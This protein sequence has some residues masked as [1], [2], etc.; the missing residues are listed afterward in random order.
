MPAMQLRYPTA[1]GLPPSEIAGYDYDAAPWTSETGGELEDRGVSIDRRVFRRLRRP[2]SAGPTKKA[3]QREAHPVHEAAFTFGPAPRKAAG[4]WVSDED[5]YTTTYGEETDDA[6]AFPGGQMRLA[7]NGLEEMLDYDSFD[8]DE[9]YEGE[10]EAYYHP[11][12]ARRQG[13]QA[14]PRSQPSYYGR[15]ARR[16]SSSPE[17]LAQ[18]RQERHERLGPAPQGRYFQHIHHHHHLHHQHYGYGADF[19]PL[20]SPSRMAAVEAPGRE[21]GEW[22]TPDTRRRASKSDP[23]SRGAAVRGLWSRDRF[24][25]STGA[26]KF[27]LRGCGAPMGQAS[28]QR[29]Q[30]YIPTFVPPHEK[31][32][33]NLRW[34]VHLQ[35]RQVDY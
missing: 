22:M 12:H 35:M 4:A 28:P 32:R 21:R 2:S 24:L 18:Q 15:V 29:V 7:G 17:L 8:D 6:V 16:S 30:G 20:E 10:L 14:R 34:Q 25:R 1:L 9:G 27:D 23:V 33:D 13:L 5:L 11:A 19:G 3:F 26:R 31:R